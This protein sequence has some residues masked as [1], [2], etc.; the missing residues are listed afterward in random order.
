MSI[1]A[2]IG[3]SSLE[4]QKNLDRPFERLRQLEENETA[5]LQ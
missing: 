1:S 4:I 2:N 5:P 3:L